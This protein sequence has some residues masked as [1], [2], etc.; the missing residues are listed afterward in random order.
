MRNTEDD[1]NSDLV[2]EDSTEIAEVEKVLSDRHELFCQN[3]VNNALL[4]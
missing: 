2:S 4:F 1:D 3:Y